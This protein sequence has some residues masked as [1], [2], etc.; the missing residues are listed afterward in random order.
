MSINNDL[1]ISKIITSL[2]IIELLRLATNYSMS[3]TGLDL[4]KVNLNLVM[5]AIFIFC[6][7]SSLWVFKKK[8]KI[9]VSKKTCIANI[10]ICF[11]ILLIEIIITNTG[12]FGKFLPLIACHSEKYMQCLFTTKNSSIFDYFF[13]LVMP[14]TTFSIYLCCFFFIKLYSKFYTKI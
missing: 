10:I 5:P 4:L 9:E 1:T 7:V 14:F 8:N 11:V 6:I 3:T 2:L 12:I 13:N